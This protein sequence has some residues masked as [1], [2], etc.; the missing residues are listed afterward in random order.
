MS[1]QVRRRRQSLGRGVD[2]TGRTIKRDRFLQLPHFL[3]TSEAWKSL[4]PI[5]RTLFIEVAQRYNGQNN[6]EIGL[7]VRAAGEALHVRP[8]TVG[9]AFHV[10]VETGFLKVGRDSAFNV[11]S[12][13]AREW[14]VTLFPHGDRLATRDFMRWRPPPAE[15]RKQMRTEPLT[16]ANGDTVS[17]K[18]TSD[19]DVVGHRECQ[20]TSV[21]SGLKRITSISHQGECGSTPLTNGVR[22]VTNS[23]AVD[24]ASMK[25]C[26]VDQEEPHGQ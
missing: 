22:P 18:R 24:P 26:A 9:N 5:E 14:I 3:L 20:T 16:V 13:L 2:A 11:K 4:N 12:R 8:Q 21:F 6:G 25:A 15:S 17:N 10:L 23:S 7:G 1:S 19:G